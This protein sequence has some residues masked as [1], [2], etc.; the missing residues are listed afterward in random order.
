MS[1]LS[2]SIDDGIADENS[3]CE[4]EEDFV[5]GQTTQQQQQRSPE[6]IIGGGVSRQNSKSPSSSV[7]SSPPLNQSTPESTTKLMSSSSGQYAQGYVE[8]PVGGAGAGSPPSLSSFNEE[9]MKRKL[10]FFFMNPI[11]KWQTRRRFPY[12]FLVQLI[13]IVIVS[14]QLCLFAHSRYNH[15]NYTWD[16]RV[17]FSHLFLRGWDS[18]NEVESY[19]PAIGPFALYVQDDFFETIDFAIAGYQNVSDAIGP[20]SYPNEENVMAPLKLCL[21]QYKQGVI[22][23]FNES[24]IFNPDII[25]NCMNLTGNVTS[26]GSKDYLAGKDVIISFSAL[27]K[28]TLEFSLKTVNFK[29]SVFISNRIETKVYFLHL[30]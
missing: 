22:F 24:Y 11:E 14:M 27:V 17:T 7:S 13:K 10:Q 19:P 25:K 15:V 1:N 26:M 12:K 3:M 9:R 6:L 20:Y 16:N 29:V 21:Y 23:G 28:A 5:R 8:T 2:S 18:T 4:S 30:F